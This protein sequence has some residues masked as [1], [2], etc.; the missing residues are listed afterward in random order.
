MKRAA[1]F[2]ACLVAGAAGA[3]GSSLVS[4]SHHTTSAEYCAVEL[5]SRRVVDGRLQ[6][7]RSCKS[8]V[9]WPIELSGQ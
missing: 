3:A 2:A 5:V 7:Q 6:E 4:P 8:W 9:G 1:F